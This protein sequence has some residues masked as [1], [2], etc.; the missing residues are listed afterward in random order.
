MASTGELGNLGEPV[1]SL[2]TLPEEQGY[3]L[4]TSPGGG[5]ELPTVNEPYGTQTEEADKGV[6]S[7]RVRSDP[8][9]TAGSRSGAQ[10]RRRWGSEAQ[11]TRWRE[12][13][14]GH[15]VR[16]GGERGDTSRTPT[17]ATP[18]QRIAEQAKHYPEM[19]FTTLARLI[20]VDFLREAYHRTRKDSA[21]G[22]DGGTA[23][24]YAE[25]RE[26]NLRDLHGRLRSGRSQAPPVKR[27][28]LAKASGS[29]RPRG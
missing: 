19:V 4:T 23:A 1:V 20:A 18:L 8:R 6:G 9:R 3:R 15:T 17:I 13:E 28:W 10:D 11:G 2:P 22:I 16:L 5:G 24:A 12:G 29:Q 26:E 27:H 21:P 14:A 7:E 25:H